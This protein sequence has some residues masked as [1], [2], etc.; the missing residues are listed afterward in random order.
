MVDG[1]GS[2]WRKLLREALASGEEG[3]R[4]RLDAV[5]G[6]IFFRL[7]E[8]ESRQDAASERS[9]MQQALEVIAKLKAPK[10]GFSRKTGVWA[11]HSKHRVAE[12]SNT[13]TPDPSGQMHNRNS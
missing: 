6:A 10:P 1:G 9:D 3:L 8:I 4:D 7:Q 13:Q 12:F 11:G 5:D 2:E